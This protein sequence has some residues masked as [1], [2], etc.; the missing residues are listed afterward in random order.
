MH[1]QEVGFYVD[2]ITLEPLSL[3]EGAVREGDEIVTGVMSSPSGHRFEIKNGVPNLVYPFEL[4]TVDRK[5]LAQYEERADA[6]D[7]YLPLTFSTY[8]EDEA[9]VRNHMVD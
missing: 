8:G 9:T 5:A 7:R 1:I 4:P 3:A 2:P 6:Y